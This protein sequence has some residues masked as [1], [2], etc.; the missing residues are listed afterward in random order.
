MTKKLFRITGIY[1]EI[2]KYCIAE[3][4]A[5]TFEKALEY[6]RVNGITPRI[7]ELVKQLPANAQEGISKIDHISIPI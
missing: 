3:I 7:V 6:S 1:T 2:N 4:V 5:T